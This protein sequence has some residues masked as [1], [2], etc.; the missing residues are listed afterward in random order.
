[1]TCGIGNISLDEMSKAILPWIAVMLVALGLV[2]IFPEISLYLV[3]LI[4]VR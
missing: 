2:V 4:N 1:V 3:R